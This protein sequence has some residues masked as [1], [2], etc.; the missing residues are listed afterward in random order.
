MLSPTLDSF[1]LFLHVLA[2]SVWV[3]G[4]IVV[5]GIVPALRRTHP[6]STKTVA[7]AFGNVAWISF[8]VLFASGL[9]NLLEV[10]ILDADWQ[11]SATV[12]AHV[13]TAT[14]AGAA[15]VVHTL[16]KSKLALALGGALGLLFSLGSLFIGV[17]L[18]SGK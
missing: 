5:A 6:E 8:G 15:A 14:L 1:R 11:Y 18:R 7:R 16:G 12:M 13:A 4:Q 2:A 9:W 17:L 10:D 3:G